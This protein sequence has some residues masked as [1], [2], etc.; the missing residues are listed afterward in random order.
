MS[1]FFRRIYYLLNR[2]RLEQELR[3]DMEAHREMLGAHG[4]DF[5]NPTLLREQAREAWGWGW[6]DRLWQDLRFGAR[7]LRKSPAL[8]LTATAVLAL[9]VGVNITAFNLVDVMFFRPLPVRDPHSLVQFSVEAPTFSSGDLP[10]AA[11]MYYAA[12]NNVFSSVLAQTSTNLTLT[13]E[14]NEN[15]HAGLVSANYFSELGSSPAYG[16][17]FDPKTDD[18]P[19]S[20]PVVVLGYRYWQSHFGGD[21]TAVGRTIRLNQHPATIIGV[22]SFNF[23]GLDV[24]HGE[25]DAVWLLLSRFAYFVPDTKLL[26][27]FD[28]SESGVHMSARL[29]PGITRKAAEASLAPISQELVRQHSTVLSKELRLTT[30]PGGYAAKLDPADAGLISM[31]G[32]F[33]T[34][35]LLILATACS[36]LGSL[37]LGHA[38]NREHEISI[39][40]AL[41]ATRRRILRQLM[42]EHFLLA[43]LGSTA[44]LFL[45]WSICHPLAVWLGAAGN[46]DLGPDW[47]TVLFSFGIG[48]VACLLF[49]LPPARQ[50]AQS[51]RGKSRA[52]V[53]FMSTQV[54]ASCVL[55]VVSSLLVRALYRVSNSDPGFDYAHVITIDPQ[56]YAHGYT[57][58]KAAGFMRDLQSRLRAVPGVE[59]AALTINPPM[60]NS[61]SF[62]PAHGDVT[63]N[64]HF[65]DISPH[66]FETLAIPVL[67]GRDFTQQDADANVAI[68]SESCARVL[69]P[70]KDPLQQTFTRGNRK[71]QV[72]GVVGNARITAL[73]NG[74]DAILYM[75]LVDKTAPQY[76]NHG[77][78]S[79]VILVRTSQPPRLLVGT[80]TDLARAANPSLSP[81]VQMLSATLD[82]RRGDSEKFASVVGGMGMMALVLSMVGLWG[83]VAYGVAQRT[84]EIGIR[85]AL[86]A[87][88][89][90]IVLDMVS[91]VFM[92]LSI[93]MAGGLALSAFLSTIIRQFC[94]A[95]AVG[96]R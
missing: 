92:P 27:S 67:R 41:G 84:K 68:A 73:R 70:G 96:T 55:L 9:G 95:S 81:N 66:F 50:A 30:K 6:L 74:D 52:R 3:Q 65:N 21:P 22:T 77:I 62:Q 28:F 85:I 42:T 5:G 48:V 54:A 20:P 61:A 25:S 94:M 15:L 39:R 34:L 18:L 60:G 40:L 76:S 24:E 80:I 33:A 69:W 11:V 49:G 86:G 23:T 16:R 82:D 29:R 87:T 89:S 10:Y 58:E 36:N 71:L 2:R 63:V 78:D 37:L 14:P 91:N 8:V 53:V 13:S 72:I 83:V 64:V 79:A 7:L 17:L 19:D 59:S 32:L 1:E 45:S 75:P 38:A 90:R 26:T 47:R 46:L 51:T 35:V 44:G 12:N 93:A 4:Q 31:F 43:L 57:P 56:L 88:S